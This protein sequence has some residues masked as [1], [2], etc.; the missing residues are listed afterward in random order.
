MLHKITNDKSD[1]RYK[2][3]LIP[4]VADSEYTIA[5][6]CLMPYEV[7]CMF[8]SKNYT[9]SSNLF[10]EQR[11]Y[12][13]LSPSS[14]TKP[15]IYD[16]LIKDNFTSLLTED[17]F[18]EYYRLRDNLCLVLKVPSACNSS[19]VILEGNHTA[20]NDYK[21][22]AD[23][24]ITPNYS[25]TNYEGTTE[26]QFINI[27]LMTQ[28]QLLYIN[29]N[30]SHPFAD[31]LVGYLTGNT[32]TNMTEISSDIKRIQKKLVEIQEEGNNPGLIKNTNIEIPYGIWRNVFRNML[33]D[34]DRKVNKN[35][36]NNNKDILGYCDK[37]IEK[38]L[39]LF[40]SKGR[41]IKV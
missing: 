7:C 6:D 17:E 15:F 5:I 33:Y 36:F 10:L 41:D 4:I 12:R 29:S 16:A 2:Y 21:L 28:S 19:I 14:F 18:N 30:I 37:D 39:S 31:K 35:T 40:K 27:P 11:T 23:G 1:D 26:E 25:I 22:N 13:K 3:Y 9:P 38:D 8:Y 24:S 20:D 34:Y 32:I